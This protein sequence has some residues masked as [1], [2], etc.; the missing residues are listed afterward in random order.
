MTPPEPV[1]SLAEPELP[2]PRPEAKT[3]P[4]W[5]PLL[6]ER[7]LEL[8]GRGEVLPA[9]RCWQEV[10]ELDPANAQALDYLNAA[11]ENSNERAPR[12]SMSS[13][14]RRAEHGVD[15]ELLRAHLVEGNYEAAWQVL[16]EAL[17]L[18]PNDTE[19]VRARDLL[20]PR[21]ALRIAQRMRLSL[22]PRLAPGGTRE[23]GATLAEHQRELLRLA[24][25][26]Q[27]YAEILARSPFGEVETLRGLRALQELGLL[28]SSWPRSAPEPEIAAAE[29]SGELDLSNIEG[30]MRFELLADLEELSAAPNGLSARCVAELT[31]ALRLLGSDETV[32]DVAA[33]G[34]GEIQ[35]VRRIGTKGPMASVTVDRSLSQFGL[36]RLQVEIACQRLERP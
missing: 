36:A 25:S 34:A 19:L 24:E 29:A 31:L 20:E 21:V 16:E 14:A 6:L 30:L 28:D 1:R 26:S 13:R 27:T 15:R 7:G 17:R 5:V 9:M 11:S 10:L 3:Q 22:P 2:K 35:V 4:D 12:S 32:I 18:H 23:L 33:L 8:F